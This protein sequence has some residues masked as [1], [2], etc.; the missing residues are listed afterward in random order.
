MYSDGIHDIRLTRAQMEQRRFLAIKDLQNGMKQA[1]VAR[2]FGVSRAAVTQWLKTKDLEG[3]DGLREHK[4]TGRPIKL[5]Q[6]QLSRLTEILVAG[7]LKSGFSSDIWTGK[8]VATV[9]RK[10]FR[11]EYHFK[12]IPKLLRSLG[13]RL[14]KPKK[15][16]MEQN[17]SD[18]D[19]WIETTWE[20]VKKT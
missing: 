9:I 2:K 4:A 13:F 7:A 11:V 10:N 1:D 3:I 8:R 15:R 18:R 16:A 5:D 20:Q 14:R 17:D 12:H 19:Y 6:V